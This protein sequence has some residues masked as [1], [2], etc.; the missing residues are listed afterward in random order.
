MNQNFVARCLFLFST[1]FIFSGQSIAQSSS[2][3]SLDA[4]LNKVFKNDFQL[5]RSSIDGQ[6]Y[7]AEAESKDVLPDPVFFAA[8]QNMPT[9][10]FELD[11][12]GMTMF[13]VGV[14]QMFPKGNSLTL[15]KNIV[16]HNQVEQSLQQKQRLLKLRQQVEMAWLEAWYWQKSKILI[17]ED[18]T[19]LTQMQDFMQSVYQ[20]GGNNQSDLIGA[21]LELI[22]L[23]EKILETD[24]SFQIFRHELNTLAN[25]SL[26]DVRLSENL[27]SLPYQELPSESD[28]YVLLS[29]HP[30]LL[31]L[32]ENIAQ[33]SDKIAL[34][35]QDYEPQWGVEF[36]YGYRQN[37]PNGMDRA[38]LVSAGVS[39]QLPLFSRSQKSQSVRSIKYKQASVENKRLELLQKARFELENL[40]QQYRT[41][42]AQA[43]LYEHKILP[44][45]AKQKRSAIQS[46][47]SDKGD[48]R[49]VTDLYLKVQSTKIKHQRLKV[50]EQILRSKMNYWLQKGPEI[51]IPHDSHTQD[52]HDQEYQ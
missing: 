12:E 11:Q 30:E 43:Q 2:A 18:R 15:N 45:L 22:K 9:D 51:D 47:Q 23:D 20:L 32:D 29:T 4:V 38:D 5:A 42:Q 14:K 17:E 7:M 16:L 37:M 27:V 25:V 19:F 10:T 49:V 21:E 36:S 24:R 41:T 40:A 6:V 33:L 28:L 39:V 13:K 26:A 44:T 8:M 1:L 34:S 46:Y 50:S 48:F 31:I 3:L 52:K 35:E